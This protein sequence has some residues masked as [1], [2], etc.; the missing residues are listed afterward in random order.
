MVQERPHRAFHLSFLAVVV[1][2]TAS[3]ASSRGFAQDHAIGQHDYWLEKHGTPD[4]CEE[5]ARRLGRLFQ[6]AS[7]SP[8]YPDRGPGSL[9]RAYVKVRL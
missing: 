8:P 3:G 9:V 2:S 5:A 4:E 1:R 7:V 6:V